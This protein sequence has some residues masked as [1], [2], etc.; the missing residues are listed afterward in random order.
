MLQVNAISDAEKVL[1]HFESYRSK[2]SALFP[3]PPLRKLDNPG[4]YKVCMH[5]RFPILPRWGG[6]GSDA[7]EVRYRVTNI[8][9]NFK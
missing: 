9:E 6:G 1:K 3:M 8:F 4:Y 5:S 7:G 2:F